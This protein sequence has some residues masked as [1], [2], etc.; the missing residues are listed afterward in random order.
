[1]LT[2]LNISGAFPAEAWEKRQ[3]KKRARLARKAMANA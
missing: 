3:E 1:M 2:M